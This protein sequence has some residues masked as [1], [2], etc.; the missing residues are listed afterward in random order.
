MFAVRDMTVALVNRVPAP[1]AAPF[2]SGGLLARIVAPMLECLLPTEPTEIVVRSGPAAGLRLLVDTQREKYY[3]TGTH[4]RAV[5]EVFKSVLRPGDVVWDV[6]AH[7][8]FFSLLASRLVGPSGAVVAFEPVD[9]NRSRLASNLSLSDARN[10][11]VRAEAVGSSN[12]VGRLQWRGS[13]LMWTLRQRDASQLGP[14][15]ACIRL[16]DLA[17]ELRQPTLIKIDVEGAELEV[18]RAAVDFFARV[19]PYIV[20]ELDRRPELDE[21]RQLLPFYAFERV[22][23]N[24]WFLRPR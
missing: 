20:L 9:E 16:D 13:S 4:E 10:V 18:L 22:D 15:V 21:L 3:W 23:R 17:R 14:V 7:I 24:H 5:Q 12:G 8:G 19:R 11:S 1:V 2:R 6:G